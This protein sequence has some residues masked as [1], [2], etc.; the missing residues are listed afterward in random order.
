MFEK[1]GLIFCLKKMLWFV[2][3]S[4][5]AKV[6]APGAVAYSG[7]RD[8]TWDATVEGGFSRGDVARGALESGPF[9]LAGRGGVESRGDVWGAAAG[10][11]FSSVSSVGGVYEAGI[12]FEDAD[13]VEPRPSTAKPAAKTKKKEKAPV[14]GKSAKTGLLPTARGSTVIKKGERT[15]A[16]VAGTKLPVTSFATG[17]GKEFKPTGKVDFL[18]TDTKGSLVAKPQT[19]GFFSDLGSFQENARTANSVKGMVAAATEYETATKNDDSRIDGRNISGDETR[20]LVKGADILLSVAEDLNENV[21]QQLVQM[22]DELSRRI[23]AELAKYQ[24]NIIF[25]QSDFF[26][27]IT[28]G[29]ADLDDIGNFS[30]SEAEDIYNDLKDKL[31]KIEENAKEVFAGGFK[32]YDKLQEFVKKEVDRMIDLVQGFYGILLNGRVAANQVLAIKDARSGIM[33]MLHTIKRA[34][35]P[36]N[37]N[38]GRVSAP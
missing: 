8:A 28:K 23:R 37:K 27:N 17:A 36:L 22:I 21:Y 29:K 31:S 11:D 38:E 7:A 15:A 25:L 30:N 32:G 1:K 4:S 5:G 2:V 9:S 34:F 33:E 13:K 35:Q 20:A 18:R 3:F 10:T 24:K 6:Y 19:T 26:K 14:V 12:L 16:T